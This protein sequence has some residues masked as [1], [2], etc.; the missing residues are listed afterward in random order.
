[1]AGSDELEVWLELDDEGS[2]VRKWRCDQLVAV[3]VD[4]FSAYRLAMRTDLDLHQLVDAAKGGAT[5]PQ[6]TDLFI[7]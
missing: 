7:D 5:G 6:L 2:R 4:A 3:G 1:M